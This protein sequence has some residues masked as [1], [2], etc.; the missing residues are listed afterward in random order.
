MSNERIRLKPL[1]R[2]I[3]QGD[4]SNLTPSPDSSWSTY[5]PELYAI[6]SV[7]IDAS[8]TKSIEF[9]N[10]RKPYGLYVVEDDDNG[11]PIIRTV[12]SIDPDDPFNSLQRGIS[13]TLYLDLKSTICD[14]EDNSSHPL[15]AALVRFNKLLSHKNSQLPK[16]LQR[17]TTRFIWAG[18]G[19]ATSTMCG[20]LEVIACKTEPKNPD[21]M[22]DTARKSFPLVN[23]LAALNIDEF[24][25]LDE[26]LRI[27]PHTRVHEAAYDPK[28]FE[29]SQTGELT[30]V[31][32]PNSFASPYDTPTITTGCPAVIDLGKGSAIRRLWD[33][34]LEIVPAIY[35]N[36]S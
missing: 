18:I 8:T 27:R 29:I 12:N 26:Y 3:Q 1:A 31:T 17:S 20:I 9:K 36:I 35:R 32:N 30:L 33:W 13:H 28:N 19:T 5:K 22:L 7:L 11:I 4:I 25:P 14:I 6:A 10:K 21:Q 24:V 15:H 23:R 34:H 16:D 2:K